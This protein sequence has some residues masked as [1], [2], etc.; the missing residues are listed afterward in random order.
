MVKLEK[1][2]LIVKLDEANKLNDICKTQFYLKWIKI[3]SLDEEHVKFKA[4]L[5]IV[6]S[7]NL[8]KGPKSN[9]IKLYIPP[10]KRDH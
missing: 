8:D 9:D 1:E 7:D 3:K 4:K 2:E 10:F 6:S 5:E